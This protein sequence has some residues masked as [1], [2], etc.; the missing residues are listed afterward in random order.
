MDKEKAWAITTSK[1]RGKH[2]I[3]LTGD[4]QA[5]ADELHIPVID[6]NNKGIPKLMDLYQLDC[7]L[8]EEED[9]LILMAENVSQIFWRGL[10]K[11]FIPS[12]D[13]TWTR[14]VCC[15]SRTTES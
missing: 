4:A 1:A 10:A 3:G 2:G 5:L 6:R 13:S 14:T 12:A 7:I 8:V 15:F 9:E 11:E